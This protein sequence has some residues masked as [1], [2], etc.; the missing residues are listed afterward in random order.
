MVL[1]TRALDGLLL[2][3]DGGGNVYRRMVFQKVETALCRR[4]LIDGRSDFYVH[5]KAARY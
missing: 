2:V 5:D 1:A 4:T 3:L